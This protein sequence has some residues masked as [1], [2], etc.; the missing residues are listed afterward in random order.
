[1]R[2]W[3]KESTRSRTEASQGRCQAPWC[4]APWCQAPWCQAP[5]CQAPWCLAP[6]LG[7]DELQVGLQGGEVEA[8]RRLPVR[9]EVRRE[10][11][12]DL[13]AVAVP[14]RPRHLLQPSP[15]DDRDAGRAVAHEVDRVAAPGAGLRG[16]AQ[17]A[18]PVPD[19]LLL[20]GERQLDADIQ[21]AEQPGRRAGEVV[22]GYRH[23]RERAD[24]V[25]AD[26][27]LPPVAE[28]VDHDGAL[29]PA[30]RIDL[31]H[32]VERAHDRA[33]GDLDGLPGAL[34]RP[35][36]DHVASRGDR[37]VADPL[38]AVHR[39][40][41]DAVGEIELGRRRGQL[42]RVDVPAE[43]E[44]AHVCADGQLA[45]LAENGGA[46]GHPALPRG[47]VGTRAAET[48]VAAAGESDPSRSSGQALSRAQAA[49]R[50][51]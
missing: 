20:R 7:R 1:Y 28:D 50:P 39:P 22:I 2:T 40:I 25:P 4:Q 42:F 13:V 47:A 44:R 16:A 23:A 36:L 8:V 26:S 11:R 14:E 18:R 21:P 31:L 49:S 9:E 48:A 19:L 38:V 45:E 32:V 27:L 17:R 51:R 15:R 3:S 41:L 37:A 43:A 33:L 24:P 46:G 30:R 29:L 35:R 6:E 10:D 12:V 34:R 5:W